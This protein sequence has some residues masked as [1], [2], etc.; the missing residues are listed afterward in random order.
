MRLVNKVDESFENMPIAR[1]LQKAFLKLDVDCMMS[2]CR[3]AFAMKRSDFMTTEK[4][5]R[6][7]MPYTM[8][9]RYIYEHQNLW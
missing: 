6:K 4:M 1:I 9:F 2:K 3:F 7:G 8:S 5:F